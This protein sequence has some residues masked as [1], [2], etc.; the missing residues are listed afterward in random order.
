MKKRVLMV[1]LSMALVVGV[2]GI[3]NA[4]TIGSNTTDIPSQAPNASAYVNHNNVSGMG[5]VQGTTP[6]LN[7]TLPAQTTQTQPSQPDQTSPSPDINTPIKSSNASMNHQIQNM[8]VNTQMQAMPMSAPMN[9]PMSN[10]Q[11]Q[12]GMSGTLRPNQANASSATQQSGQKSSGNTMMGSTGR[13]G[14]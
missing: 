7:Q 2:A 8:P 4:A 5:A 6:Q 9:G 1:T 3:V 10:S 13:M 14:K 12:Q 11:H